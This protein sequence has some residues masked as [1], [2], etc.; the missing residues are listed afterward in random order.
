MDETNKKAKTESSNG[1]KSTEI[2]VK[3][4]TAEK[5][6]SEADKLTLRAW[7]KTFENHKKAA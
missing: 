3:A 2:S 1:H 6:M 4:K 7:K 5:S